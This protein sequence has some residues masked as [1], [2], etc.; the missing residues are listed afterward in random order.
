MHP[1]VAPL[2]AV[3]LTTAGLGSA[4]LGSPAFGQNADTVLLNGR[5]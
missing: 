1:I 2:V 5:S 3:V 4:G